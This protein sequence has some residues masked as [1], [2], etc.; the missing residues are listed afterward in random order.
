[1]LRLVALCLLFATPALAQTWQSRGLEDGVWFIGF[2]GPPSFDFIFQCGGRS[3]QNLPFENS[4]ITE[5]KLTEPG[6]I[7][8]S[9]NPS[10][11]DGQPKDITDLALIIDGAAY[12][13]PPLSYSEFDGFFETPLDVN[14]P[15]F[16]G[17]RG[18]TSA[19]LV[20]DGTHIT[21]DIPLI[22]SSAAIRTMSQVCVAGWAALPR[23]V[24]NWN[25]QTVIAEAAR[26]C[27]GPAE[28]DMTYVR[29]QDLD[30]DNHPDLILDMA[31]VDCTE[32]RDRLGWGAG[33]CGASHCSSF[34]YLSRG[35]ADEPE[36][37]LAI[38][39]RIV[40]NDAGQVRINAGAGLSTCAAER[41]EACEYQFDPTSGTLE[42][43]GLVP[44]EPLQ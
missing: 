39:T 32:T 42:Y 22:G 33:H 9:V 43:L 27:E 15:I 24:Q 16:A 13:V 10:L 28:V 7:M 8:L 4:D 19:A 41:F 1:M 36:A 37:I 40:I 23:T 30:G 17:L 20:W 31:G 29:I 18:G 3:A 35:M 14:D 11:F 38:G 21:D 34:V 12:P 5:P 25:S 2:A 26:Y 6:Q 44:Y